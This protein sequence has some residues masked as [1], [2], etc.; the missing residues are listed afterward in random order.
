MTRTWERNSETINGLWPHCQWT[1]EEIDLWH[2]DLSGLDQDVLFEAIRE[3]KRSRD[4][5]YPQLAWIH[6]AYRPLIAA[7]RAADRT[8]RAAA[9]PAF[10]GDRLEI[11]PAESRRLAGLIAAR[12]EAAG[13]GDVDGILETIREHIDQIDAPVVSRL[14]WRASAKRRG[15][16]AGAAR[17]NAVP[18]EIQESGEDFEDVRRKAL[19]QLRAAHD[20]KT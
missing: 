2:A 17:P 9:E 7:K 8:A 12:I 1:D 18:V 4:S 6:A 19:S 10:A 5:L 16:D 15:I 3:V 14:A 20:H 11:D 13:P